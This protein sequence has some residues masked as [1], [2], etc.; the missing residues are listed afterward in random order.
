MLPKLIETE[1]E[2]PLHEYDQ[3]NAGLDRK[4]EQKKKKKKPT[5]YNLML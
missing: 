4:K 3:L 5:K 1:M 2:I